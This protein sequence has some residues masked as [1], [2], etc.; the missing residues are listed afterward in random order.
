VPFGARGSDGPF[1]VRVE[2]EGLT[3][4]LPK[5]ASNI[6]DNGRG[7]PKLFSCLLRGAKQPTLAKRLLNCFVQFPVSVSNP[8]IR[9][10]FNRHKGT[11]FITK[12]NTDTEIS[13]LD[14][15]RPVTANE[16]AA[17]L[18]RSRDFVIRAA[19]RGDLRA[20]KVGPYAVVYW[21]EDVRTWLEGK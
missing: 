11:G 17:W 18:H 8:S 12:L 19:K 16:I 10:L 13:L 15:K 14:L 1:S 6:P 20:R 21:P 5:W 2:D 4:T 7:N 9:N 3:R